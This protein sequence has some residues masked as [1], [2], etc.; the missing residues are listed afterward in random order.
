MASNCILLTIDSLRADYASPEKELMPNLNELAT[1]GVRYTSAYANGYSTPVSFPSIL[2]GTYTSHF[3]GNA[4][5]SDER[6]FL[7]SHFN[8]GGYQTAAFH[9]NPHLRVEK[10]YDTGFDFYNDFD[11]EAGSLSQIRH[12]ITNALDNDSRLY[13]YLRRIYH[14]FRMTSGSADYAKAPTINSRAED[15]LDDHC[16]S[17]T[18]FF[19]WL[20]YM[21]PH[22]PFIP[23]E[24]FLE[25]VTSRDISKN[26]AI[27]LNG[28]MHEQSEE[29]DDEDIEDLRALYRADVRYTDHHIGEFIEELESRGLFDDTLLA[30]TADHGE[31]FGEHDLF[32]HPPAGYDEGIRVPLVLTGPGVP[33]NETYGG[34]VSLV[35]LAPTL[36]ELCGLE[37]DSKWEGKSLVSTFEEDT[38][39]RSLIIGDED[40]LAYQ[41]GRWRLVW[42]R[43]AEH[44]RDPDCEWELR[45]VTENESVDLSEQEEIVSEFESELRAHIERAEEVTSVEGP[46]TDA[47][48]QDQLEAL[49]YK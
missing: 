47:D 45:D 12:L 2:T 40:V 48:V 16:Q 28:K 32:G 25:Q 1:S 34:G 44:S 14:L 11:E 31:F 4:Y 39:T 38:E 20:H 23:P 19:L 42:W 22:Y 37:E 17:E 24:E 6:P 9:T 35:D 10:N 7:A 43:T 33:E 13:K 8:E 5:M 27:S 36:A 46:E 49:G 30:I 41:R 29:M 21:D 3:G 26:R 15:W 18:P